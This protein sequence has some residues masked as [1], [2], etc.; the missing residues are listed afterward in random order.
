MCP[1]N[2]DPR[3]AINMDPTTPQTFDNAYYKNLQQGN[4][5]FTS[6]QVLFMDARSRPTVNLFASNNNAFNQAFVST[7]TK[8][9]RVGVLTGY[10]G[11]IRRDYRRVN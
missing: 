6:D 3:I 7:V 10:Q 11:E 4:G 2:V 1:V 8:L 9:G 5:L